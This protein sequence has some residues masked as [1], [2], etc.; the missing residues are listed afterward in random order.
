M[1][2]SD[3]GVMKAEIPAFLIEMSEQLNTQKNRCT[4]DPI[5]VV[6]YDKEITCADDR[7]C[8]TVWFDC[9]NEYHEIC[10]IDGGAD[11]A[12][13]AE[14]LLE[15]EPGIMC[16]WCEDEGCCATDFDIDLHE[17]ILPDHYE[18]LAM[19]ELREKVKFCLTEADAQS[20]ISRK[21]HDYPKLYIYVES[22]AFCPQMIELREW[23]K[24]L[25]K[26][27]K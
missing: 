3:G 1:G 9:E 7:G 15:H 17:G 21:Q 12:L 24:G 14:Y 13:M 25:V 19:Q 10:E 23:I 22:M 20:F 11:S 18:K 26:N 27:G 16:Q 8:R 4:R 2:E 5:F 6:C